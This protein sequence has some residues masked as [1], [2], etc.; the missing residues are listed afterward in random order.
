[1]IDK[2]EMFI[3][4]AHERHFGK[5]AEECGV[6][7]PTLSANIKQLEKQLGVLLVLRGSRFQGITPEGER[8]LEWARKLVAD[9]R[10]MKQELKAV[11]KG[12]TGTLR[13]ASIPTALTYVPELTRC[14]SED[15][16]GISYRVLSRPSSEILTQ[17]ENLEIDI[18]LTYLDNE[19]L[20]R[21]LRIPLYKERYC[22]VV[23]EGGPLSGAKQVSLQDVSEVPLCLLTTDMQCRRIVDRIFDELDVIA[24]PVL[25]S[26]S[27]MCLL[28]HVGT[29]RWGTVIPQGIAETIASDRFEIIPISDSYASVMVG[30]I[31]TQREP[32]APLLDAF[33][34][35]VAQDIKDC[36]VPLSASR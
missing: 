24:K 16:P 33:L 22:F 30:L 9:T 34:R 1:M 35:C 17:L 25:Q 27:I 5:A 36:A 28:A 14:F 8:V 31:A 12:Q 6:T 7:Q 13:I 10:T 29:G 21:V 20:G 11:R 18:G 32:R 23:V 26:D 4:L 19:P 3:A 15:N 2:L